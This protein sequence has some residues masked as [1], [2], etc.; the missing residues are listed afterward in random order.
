MPSVDIWSPARSFCSPTFT[1]RNHLCQLGVRE[2]GNPTLS[3]STCCHSSEPSLAE[4]VPLCLPSILRVPGSFRFSSFP[5]SFQASELT[6]FSQAT[7]LCPGE[8]A[9]GLFLMV[10]KSTEHQ[11]DR[12]HRVYVCGSVV[13]MRFT[14]LY[15]PPAGHASSS[16]T[17]TLRP[18]SPPRSPLLSAPRG[19]HPTLCP[20]EVDASRNLL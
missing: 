1:S 7:P 12:L 8:S 5:L 11:T 6:R 14:L 2:E 13:V 15:D 10:V 4:C 17:E 19:H 9:K 18:W 3:P 20:H 16:R